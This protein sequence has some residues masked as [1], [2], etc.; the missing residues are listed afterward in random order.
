MGKH[1]PLALI[2]AVWRVARSSV[3]TCRARASAGEAGPQHRRRG[4]KTALSDAELVEE[5]RRVLEESCLLG[6]EH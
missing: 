2:C 5:I 3:Y 6:E 4:P 1:Y